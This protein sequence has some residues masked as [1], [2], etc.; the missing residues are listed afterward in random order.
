MKSTKWILAAI[1]VAL[2]A[3]FVI[4]GSVYANDIPKPAYRGHGMGAQT[5]DDDPTIATTQIQH[6]GKN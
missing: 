1:S 3:D 6:H 2:V 5:G 4:A